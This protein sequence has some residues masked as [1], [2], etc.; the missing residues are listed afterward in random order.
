[1]DKDSIRRIIREELL[2]INSQN[3]NTNSIHDSLNEVSE[4]VKKDIESKNAKIIEL[5]GLIS[6]LDSKNRALN[7][8]ISEL[9]H[10]V[11]ND[12][13]TNIEKF[14]EVE[15]LVHDN[16]TK[17]L[18]SIMANQASLERSVLS[19]TSLLGRVLPSFRAI[20]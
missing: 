19:I 9:E 1:M 13:V 17:N 15:A 2:E 4:T 7:D 3:V 20:E 8:K 10:V 12:K 5:E 11:E 6:E 18:D 16:K 14:H